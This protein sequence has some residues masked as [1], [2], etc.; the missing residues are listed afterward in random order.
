MDVLRRRWPVPLLALAASACAPAPGAAPSPTADAPTAYHLLAV[1]PLPVVAIAVD[2]E[3]PGS[4]K[5]QLADGNV[6]TAWSNGGFKAATATA[7]LQFAAVTGI[8][9]IGIKTGPSPAGTQYDVQ[10][11]ATGAAWTS[12]LAGQ[13]N[14]TWNV[15][16]KSLPVGTTGK[17]LRIL[18][19]NA[20]ANPQP[21]FAIYELSAS[22]GGAVGNRPPVIAGTAQTP[23]KIT[24]G[25]QGQLSVQAS[26]PD[27]DA[28]TY[29]WHA[30]KGA[31]TGSGPSVNYTPDSAAQGPNTLDDLVTVTVSDGKAPPVARTFAVD[32]FL[33]GKDAIPA[34]TAV[35]WNP[36]KTAFAAVSGTITAKASGFFSVYNA[37]IAEYSTASGRQMALL[38]PGATVLSGVTGN[39]FLYLI[40]PTGPNTPTPNISVNLAPGVTR[41]ITQANI[42]ASQHV[43]YQALLGPG[44]AGFFADVTTAKNGTALYQTLLDIRSNGLTAG[45]GLGN[46]GTIDYTLLRPGDFFFGSDLRVSS[47]DADERVVLTDSQGGLGDNTGA[48]SIDVMAFDR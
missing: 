11:S 5:A 7:T 20:A 23:L 22:G 48:W 4:P 24:V 17:F 18:W 44:N 39:V 2:S 34:N 31:I 42:V 21:H 1:Q 12:V 46:Q 25:G 6:T 26:D 10:V 15:E 29:A 3:A 30:Q 33:G 14:T 27:G 19:H 32:T 40:G 36:A 47:G 9:Q 8:S 16:T 43:G 37:V 35:Q 41:T 28:L 45:P 38:K 13:V